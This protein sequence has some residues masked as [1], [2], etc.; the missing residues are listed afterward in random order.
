MAR[1]QTYTPPQSAD[2]TLEQMKAALPRLE[3]RIS[4]IRDFDPKEVTKRGDPKIKALENSI[5]DFLT[6]TFGEGTVEYNRYRSVAH[7][8]T[9]SIFVGRATPFQEVI[10]GLE[11][12][13]ERAIKVLEGIKG[14]FHEEIHFV[15]PASADKMAQNTQPN[16][17][18]RDILLSM[19]AITV[20]AILLHGFWRI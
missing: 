5:D 1:K 14:L 19:V 15:T 18:S 10:Q 2:L 6:K 3:L 20:C 16:S 7:L 11:H 12:G 4:D 13:K 8:D 9:A 17:T